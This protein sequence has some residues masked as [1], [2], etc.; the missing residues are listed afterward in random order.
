MFWLQIQKC[1][2]VP[3]TDKK[4]RQSKQ[5]VKK[6]LEE[7]LIGEKHENKDI[8]GKAYNV[9]NKEEVAVVIQGFEE[10]IRTNKNNIAWVA[11]HQGKITDR[12]KERQRKI[13]WTGRKIRCV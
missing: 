8:E 5:E 3:R 2:N 11:Y 12:F 6:K 4:A 10:L 1:K 7:S 9:E 13:S